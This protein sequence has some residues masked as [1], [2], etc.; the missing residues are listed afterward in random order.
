MKL[1]FYIRRSKNVEIP[2][3]RRNK[4]NKTLVILYPKKFKILENEITIKYGD[5]I[6]MV[7]I[8]YNKLIDAIKLIIRRLIKKIFRNEDKDEYI[9][10]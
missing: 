9:R 5:E 4:N 6:V 7:R 8:L 2:I 10:L 3:V 1:K